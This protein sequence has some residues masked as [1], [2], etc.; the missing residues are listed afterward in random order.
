M[1]GADDYL[2]QLLDQ[3]AAETAFLD[4]LGRADDTRPGAQAAPAAASLAVSLMITRQQ[5][6]RLRELGFSD[7]DI[8]T[9]TPAEAHRHLGL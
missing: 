4:R 3:A 2:R 9:M 8:R 7:E 6:S 5:R 1:A